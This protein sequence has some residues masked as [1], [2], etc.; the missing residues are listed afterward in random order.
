[1][2]KIPE[3]ILENLADLIIGGK[4]F[5]YRERRQLVLFFNSIGL[6]FSDTESSRLKTII[7][8]LKILNIDSHFKHLPSE[9]I[10]KVIEYL[11]HPSHF[12]SNK[13]N[14]LDMI[15]EISKLLHPLYLELA[16]RDD[17]KNV[18]LVDTSEAKPICYENK[19]IDKVKRINLALEPLQTE[20]HGQ[21]Y[22]IFISYANEDSDMANEIV[23]MIYEKYPKL[24]VFFAMK[25]L[26]AGDIWDE[27]IRN[28]LNSAPVIVLLLTPNS[29]EKKWVL[30]EVGGAW[31]QKKKVIPLYQ[32]VKIEDLPQPI[33]SNQAIAITTNKKK[34]EAV[35]TILSNFKIEEKFEFL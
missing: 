8:D 13:Y 33:K 18:L 6:N 27:S 11:A 12:I 2:A 3:T 4:N 24:K 16:W 10:T 35:D 14:Q 5:P 31:F 19:G 23:D 7:R 20:S 9:N 15:R 26:K 1:M 25:S 28:A 21:V 34:K 29:I 22:D 30:L 17:R 32:Y